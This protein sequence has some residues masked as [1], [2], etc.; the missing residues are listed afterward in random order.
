MREGR[1]R[2][3]HIPCTSHAHP[4]RMGCAVP[5]LPRNAAEREGHR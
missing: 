4:M 2:A 1:A 3:M 5:A